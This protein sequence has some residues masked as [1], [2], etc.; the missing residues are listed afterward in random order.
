MFNVR[1][2]YGHCFDNICY[3]CKLSST[4]LTVLHAVVLTQEAILFCFCIIVLWGVNHHSFKCIEP[5]T[6]KNSKRNM[7]TSIIICMIQQSDQSHCCALTGYYMF[8]CFF[9]QIAKTSTRLDLCLFVSFGI[10]PGW[11]ESFL[12]PMVSYNATYSLL[13]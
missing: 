11:S 2:L 6:M 4:Q 1:S 10:Y 8:V 7:F 5:R 9:L 3:L 12:F 13:R